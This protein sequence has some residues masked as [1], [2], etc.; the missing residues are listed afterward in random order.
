MEILLVLLVVIAVP[1]IA[2]GAKRG[3]EAAQREREARWG[4][5]VAGEPRLSALPVRQA[6]AAGGGGQA[7]GPA[8]GARQPLG[9]AGDGGRPTGAGRPVGPAAGA[10]QPVGAGAGAPSPAGG[11][12][13]T[14]AARAKGSTAGDAGTAARTVRSTASEAFRRRPAPIDL[15]TAPVSELQNL[16]G[17]GVRAAERI[18]AHREREGGFSSVD[19]LTAVEGFDQHRVSRLAP[20]AT[21]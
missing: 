12:R 20:R 19:D 9:G 14:G 8:A 16:P 18:V 10:R 5:A 3:A 7:V 6:G 21:V 17:V 15:N 11:R 2:I 1:V 13:E 4:G